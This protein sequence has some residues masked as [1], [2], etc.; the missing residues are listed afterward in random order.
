MAMIA[1]AAV[2][3]AFEVGLTIYRMLNKK[4]LPP[5]RDLEVMTSTSGSPIPFGFGTC[6]VTGSLIWT[7]GIRYYHLDKNATHGVAV[8]AKGGF[9]FYASVAVSFGEGPGTIN[10]IWADSKLIYDANP[11]QVSAVPVSDWPVWSPTELY[12]PGNQVGYL[13]NVWQCLAVNTNSAPSQ[14]NRN[15]EIVSSYPPWDSNTEYQSGDIV[16]YFGQLYVCQ[17]QNNNGIVG[18]F[19]PGNGDT[20]SIQS[21]NV[22]YWV[23]LPQ[24]YAGVG[25]NPA[26]TFYPGDENQLPDSLIQASETVALTPA[27]RRLCCLGGL[28]AF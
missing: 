22:L 3:V 7:Q 5:L 24:L 4:P 20:V 11:G 8:G 12:N 14:S 15:W 6:R 28:P 10:R 26:P 27:F 9:A 18:A 1:I 2:S 19:V 16:S 21:E 23:A 25:N 13:G 17:L